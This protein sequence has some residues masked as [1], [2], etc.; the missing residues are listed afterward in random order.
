MQRGRPNHQAM[1]TLS[2]SRL[3]MAK[4]RAQ[5]NDNRRNG[6]KSHA[7]RESA[8]SCIHYWMIETAS[9]P[10]SKGICQKCGAVGKFP[11]YAEPTRQIVVRGHRESE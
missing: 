8:P 5:I 2:K 3:V 1:V 11:N 7:L 4:K 6:Q 10:I 9:S